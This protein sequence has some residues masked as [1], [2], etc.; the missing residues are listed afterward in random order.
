MFG[1]QNWILVGKLLAITSGS[2]YTHLLLSCFVAGEY[3]KN[4]RPRY[5]Q[6]WSD[7]SFLGYKDPSKMDDEP[8]NNFTVQSKSF[9][10][11]INE[12]PHNKPTRKS[13]LFNILHL[14]LFPYA[15]RSPASLNLQLINCFQISKCIFHFQNVK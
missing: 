5:F 15:F 8:L 14:Y 13:L 10:I 2:L 6:L 7:G 12:I 11:C 4:W 3:I 1:W 9:I